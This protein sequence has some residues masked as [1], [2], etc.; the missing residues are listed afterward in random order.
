M[1]AEF[2]TDESVQNF[3]QDS[4]NLQISTSF[5]STFYSSATEGIDFLQLFCIY[6]WYLKQER[7]LTSA[8]PSN[9]MEDQYQM[10]VHYRAET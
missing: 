8:L 5:L 4:F 10:K 7:I 3:V 6:S 9:T 2:L 1:L